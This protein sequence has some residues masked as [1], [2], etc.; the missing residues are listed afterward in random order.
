MKSESRSVVSD[1]LRPNGLCSPWNSPGQ[2][3]GVGRHSLL[4]GIF[5]TQGSNPGLPHC[6]W[7]L[8][9]M[10]HQG[11]PPT[12]TLVYPYVGA[13]AGTKAD[14]ALLSSI[15]YK[16]QVTGCSPCIFQR[17]GIRRECPGLKFVDL[18]IY[19]HPKSW[20]L[21]FKFY[22]FRLPWAFIVTYGLRCPSALGILVPQP[23]L[24]L[25]S[26]ALQGRFLTTGPPGRSLGGTFYLSE[27]FTTSSPG[28]SPQK[29]VRELF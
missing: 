8:Y 17:L 6:R 14:R 27:I 18:K 22:L 21:C 5:P 20:E 9:Q 13:N 26:P 29:I 28:A 4:Q 19:A 25:T 15:C 3:T 16:P 24:E 1:S 23:G 10:S 12:S 2:N 7:I 11:N